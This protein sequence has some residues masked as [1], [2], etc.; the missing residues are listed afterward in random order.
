MLYFQSFVII[1]AG[2]CM[3][4]FLSK[5]FWWSSTW[6]FPKIVVSQNG[7]FIMENPINPWMIWGE[8]PLFSETSTFTHI[9]VGS[10]GSRCFSRMV[11]LV[12]DELPPWCMEF[13]HRKIPWRVQ[14][15]FPNHLIGSSLFRAI[16]KCAW[17][18]EIN[19]Q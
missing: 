17:L 15:G 8:N 13:F 3:F 2:M 16:L 11:G 4:V 12:V 9:V 10:P 7:W 18:Y 5:L 6:V 19:F 14:G 1:I